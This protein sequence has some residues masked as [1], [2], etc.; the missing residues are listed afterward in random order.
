MK[1]LAI[2]HGEVLLYPVQKIQTQKGSVK[3]VKE[4]NHFIVG[5]SETGHH[6]V[7]ESDVKFE[8]TIFDDNHDLYVKLFEPAKL[9]HQKTVNRHHDLTVIPG[10][11]KVIRKQEYSPFERIMR[12]VW[13]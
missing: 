3:V 8:A 10:T 6:H 13:D 5:H 11:Y 12:D 9:V 4:S 2:R 7:L 1:I